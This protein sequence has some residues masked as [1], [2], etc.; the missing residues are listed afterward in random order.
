VPKSKCLISHDCTILKGQSVQKLYY[1]LCNLVLFSYT[2]R[3]SRKSSRKC[4]IYNKVF[5]D[6]SDNFCLLVAEAPMPQVGSMPHV[7][8]VHIV[9]VAQVAEVH[10]ILMP[11]VGSIPQVAG[12]HILHIVLV[13]LVALVGAHGILHIVLVGSIRQCLQCLHV[14]YVHRRTLS[15]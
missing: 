10:M 5:S 11:L 8:G 7:A 4:T 6:F 9:L 1:A 15:T 13:A 3:N 12:V 2:L 14:A